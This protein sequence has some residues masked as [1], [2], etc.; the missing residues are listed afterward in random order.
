[1][2][3]CQG[4]GPG[5]GLLKHEDY[6]AQIAEN[7]KFVNAEGMTA[8]VHFGTHIDV[9][10]HMIADGETLDEIS[11][12]AF[13][14]HGSFIDLSYKKPAEKVFPGLVNAVADALEPSGVSITELPL[15]RDYPWRKI[16]EE[17]QGAAAT[18]E[19]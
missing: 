9:P 17:K 16:N 2:G 5:E 13:I 15:K 4:N 14:G 18:V 10:F 12:S 6:Q 3:P 1:M 8:P 19:R 11:I 7:D